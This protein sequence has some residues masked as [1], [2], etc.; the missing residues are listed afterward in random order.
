MC[1]SFV[2]FSNKLSFSTSAPNHECGSHLMVTII[3]D[4]MELTSE[5]INEVCAGFQDR[6]QILELNLV[7]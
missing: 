1:T 6:F 2:Q 3:V 7:C 4:C 5:P